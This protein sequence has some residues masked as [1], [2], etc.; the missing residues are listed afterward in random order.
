[1]N[2]RTQ[3]VYNWNIDGALEIDYRLISKTQI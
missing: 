1:M 3:A 2:F